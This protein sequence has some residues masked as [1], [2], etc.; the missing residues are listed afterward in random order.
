M[1]ISRDEIIAPR[2]RS[3]SPRAMFRAGIRVNCPG[4]KKKQKKQKKEK[5]TRRTE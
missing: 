3:V 2:R 1:P 5:H 4:A